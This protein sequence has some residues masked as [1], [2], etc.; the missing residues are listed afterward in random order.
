MDLSK[1]EEGLK[2]F[3]NLK[4]PD[5]RPFVCDGPPPKRG[6][7]V[8]G[9]NPAM[10]LAKPFDDYWSKS[11]GFDKTRY[12]RDFKDQRGGRYTRTRERIEQ[13]AAN[14]GRE[15]TLDTN[16]YWRPTRRRRELKR[17]HEITKGFIYLMSELQPKVVFA[18]GNDAFCFFQEYFPDLTK[19]DMTFRLRSWNGFEFAL[20]SGRHL[21]LTGIE[22]AENIG[23][24]VRKV[25]V[26]Q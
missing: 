6:F 24:R 5:A 16:I 15:F 14:A 26:G 3:V 9:V 21:C 19:G 23:R 11:T 7:F 2:R 12:L 25:L 20:T 18:H 17:E 10:R 8:V 4:D 13:I 1:F 22:E